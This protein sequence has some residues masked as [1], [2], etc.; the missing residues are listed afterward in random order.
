MT[1]NLHARCR[2]FCILVSLLEI[3]SMKI[4]ILLA[5]LVGIAGLVSGC[6]PSNRVA[7]KPANMSVDPGEGWARLNIPAIP[8]VCS[9]SLAGK[10]GMIN[11][12]LLEDE[13]DIK[14]AADELQ[15]AFS[16]TGKAIPDSFK[17]EDFSTDS[18][19]PGI[20]ISYTGRS[21]ADGPPDMRSHSFVTHNMLGKCVS[22]SYITSPEKESPALLEAIQKTLRV[23]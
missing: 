10:G 7:F 17:Q 16:K 2:T 9:P 12:L 4:T 19:L 11:A 20:H 13:T 5:V 22:I 6:K 1:F 15:A 18:G 21:K 3:H 23:E 14:K 8:P